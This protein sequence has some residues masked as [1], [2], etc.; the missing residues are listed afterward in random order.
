M[1]IGGKF[2][3]SLS[4]SS[5]YRMIGIGFVLIF[6]SFDNAFMS[7]DDS[8]QDFVFFVKLI[9]EWFV[10]GKGFDFWI[11]VVWFILLFVIR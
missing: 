11:L 7:S 4:V 2:I 6:F 5:H 10:H 8:F 9:E 1:E 3:F